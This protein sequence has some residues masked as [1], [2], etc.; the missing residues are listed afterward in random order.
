MVR[1]QLTIFRMPYVSDSSLANLDLVASSVF[2]GVGV[3]LAK[4][5]S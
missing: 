2:E 4:G 5:K 1:F 3:E